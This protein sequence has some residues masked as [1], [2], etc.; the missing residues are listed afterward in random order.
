MKSGSGGGEGGGGL[1]TG[2]LQHF[3]LSPLNTVYGSLQQCLASELRVNW[4]GCCFS[5]FTKIFVDINK[6]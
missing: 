4:A 6:Y 3:A 1:I 2:N 5:T